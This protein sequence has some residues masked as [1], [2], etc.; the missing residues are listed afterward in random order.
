MFIVFIALNLLKDTQ[1]EGVERLV[2]LYR[3]LF[4][5]ECYKM[6][7]AVPVFLLLS[8]QALFAQ[9]YPLNIQGGYG[10]GLYAAGDTV[11]I[12]A[13]EFADNEYFERWSGDTAALRESEDW[14]TILVMPPQAVNLTAN[15]SPV[16]Y[17]LSFDTIKAVNL[18][19]PVY[20]AFPPGYKG[21]IYFLHGTGGTANVI[22]NGLETSH[23][24]RKALHN[25]FALIVTEAEE[26]TLQQDLD[27]DDK[28]RWKTF[29]YNLTN[30][31]MANIKAI[32]DTFVARSLMTTA[33]PRYAAGISNGGFQAHS[34]AATLGFQGAVSYI[35]QGNPGL[36]NTTT[37]PTLWIMNQ[38][39]GNDGVGAAGN[40]AAYDNYLKLTSRGIC[41]AYVLHPWHPLYPERY[42]RAGFSQSLSN[43]LFDE[44]KNNGLLDNQRRPLL[45]G[46]GIFDTALL[47]PTAF[48][49]LNSLNNSQLN[50][51]RRQTDI[52]YAEHIFVDDWNGTALRFL[53]NLCQVSADQ[54][55]YLP[56]DAF[57]VF[58][59]PTTGLFQLNLNEWP[60][61]GSASIRLTDTHGRLIEVRDVSEPLS[62]WSLRDQPAGTYW[63]QVEQAGRTRTVQI[64]RW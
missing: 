46:F 52:T 17:T 44:L 61:W 22:V 28:L 31:D 35:G 55:A 26:A 38:N 25:G 30:I 34:L 2:R 33:T 20:Y 59:N 1:S 54:E 45:D 27:G 53:D 14:H 10:S 13:R 56:E 43:A 58:P 39:D 11:H 40:Q 60:A 62:L 6:K 19:K 47:K 36:F 5:T 41:S 64:A 49:V 18:V 51:F 42:M 7:I 12:F 23:F 50:N 63:I 16:T 48:P 24:A 57:A 21:V 4:K 9:T 3:C 15:F 32:T 8:A 29:P 37:V